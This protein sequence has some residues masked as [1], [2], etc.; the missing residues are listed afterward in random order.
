MERVDFR[1]TEDVSKKKTYYPQI[2]LESIIE[3][4]TARNENR[5][6]LTP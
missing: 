4:T 3:L 2:A 5:R 6:S 1:E